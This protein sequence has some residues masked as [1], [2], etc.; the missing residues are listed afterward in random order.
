M[1]EI[2][3]T[4]IFGYIDELK[5]L[6]TIETQIYDTEVVDRM[7]KCIVKDRYGLTISTAE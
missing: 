6:G 2:I 7:E 4:K 3:L 1:P 5:K